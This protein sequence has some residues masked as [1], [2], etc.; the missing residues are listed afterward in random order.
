MAKI[1][2]IPFSGFYESVHIYNIEQAIE[3]DC[4]DNNGDINEDILDSFVTG[5]DWNKL[6]IDY[7]KLYTEQFKTA[8][9]GFNSLSF[10]SLVFKQLV[11]PR[12][13]NFSTD[14]IEVELS[15]N[16]LYKLYSF[17]I[18]NCKEELEKL[19]EDRFTSHSG[20]YSYYP[21]SL[22]DWPMLLA[23]WDSVQLSQLLVVFC[24]WY[25]LVDDNYEVD[26]CLLMD[27]CLGDGSIDDVIWGNL[28][29]SDKIYNLIEE[30]RADE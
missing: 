18:E 29:S 28:D 13:Y 16:E 15:D 25:D 14:L 11:S 3:L 9:A 7:A 6:H 1:L 19:I 10:E 17:I 21:N 23:D 26:S 24:R 20:F 2:Q 12:E 4:S 8:L 27:D 30:F 5:L 22:E